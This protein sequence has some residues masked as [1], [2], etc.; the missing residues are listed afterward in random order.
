MSL[1]LLVDMNLGPKWI[2]TL[3]N[4]GFNV[5]HWSTLGDPRATDVEIMVEA[6]RHGQVVITLDYDFPMLL[7]LTRA[8]GPSV[9]HIRSKNALSKR[10]APLLIA[11]LNRFTPELAT[12]ALLVIDETQLRLRCLPIQSSSGA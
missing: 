9:V 12:G 1:S 5:T 7:A 3:R 4:H 6:L 8:R 11:A 2:P 10:F